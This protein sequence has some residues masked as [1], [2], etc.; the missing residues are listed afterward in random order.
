MDVRPRDRKGAGRSG[1]RRR[2]RGRESQ[3]RV[4]AGP[5]SH[6]RAPCVSSPSRSFSLIVRLSP[7]RSCLR[8]EYALS[9]PVP[10]LASRETPWSFF[11]VSFEPVLDQR[12]SVTCL[13]PLTKT[14]S[15]THSG[16][17]PAT[18]PV[19]RTPS[20]VSDRTF[21]ATHFDSLTTPSRTL[22]TVS[23]GP[24]RGTRRRPGTRPR[25]R[26]TGFRSVRPT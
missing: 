2:E 20:P 22:R 6:R 9:R 24:K 11:P 7:V 26:G 19:L 12:I 25:E 17:S 15:P 13:L 4:L 18:T 5:V 16:G 14:V 10:S 23:T 3:V 1:D 8:V 21:G